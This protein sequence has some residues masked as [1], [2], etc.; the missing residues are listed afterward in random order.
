MYGRVMQQPN[1]PPDLFEDAPPRIDERGDDDPLLQVFAIAPTG[2]REDANQPPARSRPQSGPRARATGR[3]RDPARILFHRAAAVLG[4][5]LAV[6]VAASLVLGRPEEGTQSALKP[7]PTVAAT[8][9]AAPTATS[10]RIPA[11]NRAK[12]VGASRRPSTSKRV[13]RK[14]SRAG[15]RK[16]SRSTTVRQ[17]V[18]SQRQTAASAEYPAP[19]ATPSPPPPQPSS[20]PPV[21]TARSSPTDRTKPKRCEYPPC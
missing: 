4:G 8:P 5:G 6:M 15:K 7:E 14:P 3:R 16:R 12:R 10:D 19:A 9:T 18:S 17:P 1:E 20:S 13:N 2:E 21:Q 11:A